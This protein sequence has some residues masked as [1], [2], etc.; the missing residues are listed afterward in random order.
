MTDTSQSV[1]SRRL[2]PPLLTEEPLSGR[3]FVVTVGKVF[4]NGNIEATTKYDVTDQFE[5]L[6]KKRA[7]VER[8]THGR[9]CTC[10]ACA[11]EDWTNADLAPCGMHGDDCPA[12]YQPWGLAGDPLPPREYRNA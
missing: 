5:A 6:A 9:H 10:S 7:G 8:I 3:V 4:A 11:R 12:L 1:R 2:N